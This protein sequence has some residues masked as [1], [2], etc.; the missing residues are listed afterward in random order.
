MSLTRG[1]KTVSGSSKQIRKGAVAKS[2]LRNG[3]EVL[4]YHNGRLKV[5]RKEFGKIF[6][7]EFV[8]AKGPAEQKELKTFA[9]HSD[10]KTPQQNALKIF[11]GGVRVAGG[12]LTPTTANKFY[13]AIPDSGDSTTLGGEFQKSADGSNVIPR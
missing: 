8:Q 11:K 2:D 3:Q 1:R 4:Q 9:K 6:E 13:A 5:I 12:G 10:I 7:L